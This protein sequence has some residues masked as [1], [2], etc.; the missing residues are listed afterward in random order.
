MQIRITCLLIFLAAAAH[1]QGL[2][3]KVGG[4]YAIPSGSQNLFTTGSTTQVVGNFTTV[5]TKSEAVK[6]SYGAGIN[7]N[8]AVGYKFSPFIGLDLNLSYLMGKS[9]E[10]TSTISTQ[11]GDATLNETQ[12]SSG[13]FVSP[14]L[15]FMAG[16]EK[17]RP[18]AIAGVIM[19]S[20]NREDKSAIQ[21]DL[22]RGDPIQ[23]ELVSE[24]K[25]DMAF[26]FR[27]G[28]GVDFNINNNTSLYLE[29]IFNSMSYYAKEKEVT[30]Y[31]F[32]GDDMMGDLTES[33]RKTIYVDQTTTV[34]VDGVENND[35]DQPTEELRSPSPLSS[36][37]INFGV[38]LKFGSD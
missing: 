5:T 2:Y 8:A 26:G 9:F 25:G 12:E 7:F 14:A 19:G 36:L 13:F 38:K 37:G 24:T 20:L 32:N 3:V 34:T 6:G 29:G 15:M 22:L 21:T 30:K 11:N 35:P 31:T 23:Y 10:G 1:G 16:T 27:G 17:V 28:M 33:Q 4:G 18:Y